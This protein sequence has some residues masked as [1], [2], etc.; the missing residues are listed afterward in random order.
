MGYESAMIDEW[1]GM[2]LALAMPTPKRAQKKAKA[3]VA[4]P[5]RNTMAVKKTLDQ[6]MIGTRLMRS[7]AQPIGMAP[8]TTKALEEAA[9]KVM[10]PSLTPKVSRMSGARTV[11]AAVWSSS[12][13]ARSSRITKV[14]APPPI[15]RPLRMLM[16][17]DLTPGSSSSAKITSLAAWWASRRASS[18]RTV[19]ASVEAPDA[20]AVGVVR[21]SRGESATASNP[22]RGQNLTLCQ[23]TDRWM[24]SRGADL[25]SDGHV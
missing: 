1:T 24:L 16:P 9:M 4:R 5:D 14:V 15:C 10:A 12:R 7:A 21:S 3:L 19:A 11:M 6:P 13:E 2:V 23:E 25:P 17:S 22:T 18:S 8:N 20:S